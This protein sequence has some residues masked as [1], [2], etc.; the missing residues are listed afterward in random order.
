MAIDLTKWDNEFDA[1]ELNKE[2]EEA[3]KNDYQ[4]VPEGIYLVKVEKM[5]LGETG[6][7]SKRPGSPM[8]KVQL[9]IQKGPYKKQCLFQNFVLV[10]TS[11]DGK[12]YGLHRAKDFLRSLD[13]FETVEF[14]GFKDFNNMIMDM[15][16]AIEEDGLKYEVMYTIK[17]GFGSVEVTNVLES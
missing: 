3:S 9:R 17:N 11:N 12:N 1:N 8:L 4:E 6:P 7:K 16:E 15:M 2:A 13:V 10:S 5:E 14:S